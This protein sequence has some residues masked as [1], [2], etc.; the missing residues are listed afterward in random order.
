MAPL[1]GL[2]RRVV[3]GP[4]ARPSTENYFLQRAGIAAA[5]AAEVKKAEQSVLC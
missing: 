5:G 1:Q 3:A 2:N 4:S